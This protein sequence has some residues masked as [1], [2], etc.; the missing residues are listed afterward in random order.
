MKIPS[1]IRVHLENPMTYRAGQMDYGCF[2]RRIRSLYET[3]YQIPWD[4][5][6]KMSAWDKAHQ[7]Y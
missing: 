2:R 1:L 7:N 3:G 5:S 6:W 4:G